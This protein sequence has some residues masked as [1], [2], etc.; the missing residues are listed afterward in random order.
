MAPYDSSP[1][2]N[3]RQYNGLWVKRSLL[4]RTDNLKMFYSSWNS[5]R[6]RI[7]RWVSW[8]NSPSHSKFSRKLQILFSSQ[9]MSYKVCEKMSQSWW[10][11][12]RTSLSRWLPYEPTKQNNGKL[13]LFSLFSLNLPQ[14]KNFLLNSVLCMSS[15]LMKYFFISFLC[16]L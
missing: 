1:P 16:S 5:I 13:N 8:L 11:F 12:T 10:N 7:T 4:L 9:L 2:C 6:N 3:P 15:G 14:K